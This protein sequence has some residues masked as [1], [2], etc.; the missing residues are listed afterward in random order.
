MVM[1]F[2]QFCVCSVDIKIAA[3]KHSP[4]KKKLAVRTRATSAADGGA[5]AYPEDGFT[6]S[7]ESGKTRPFPIET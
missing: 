5:A 4:S 1:V 6:A 7:Q 2:N 3:L